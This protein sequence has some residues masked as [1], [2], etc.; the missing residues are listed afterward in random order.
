[1][2]IMGKTQQYI[3]KA[4]AHNYSAGHSWDHLDGE[5]CEKAAAEIAA[6][7]STIASLTAERDHWKTYSSGQGKLIESGVFVSNED[8]VRLTTAEARI[9]VLEKA[10]RDIV[11][12]WD[13]GWLMKPSIDEAR[14]ALGAGQPTLEAE[15]VKP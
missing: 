1:M 13:R 15:G 11:Q 6:K 10:L 7:D 14:A 12:A 8:Y 9:A 3:L 4:M 2:A 5:A